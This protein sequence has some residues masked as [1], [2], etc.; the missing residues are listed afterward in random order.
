ML[1]CY[2]EIM[3]IEASKAPGFVVSQEIVLIVEEN[4]ALQT[5]I[6]YS[7]LVIYQNTLFSH[8][9]ENKE[10]FTNKNVWHKI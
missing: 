5:Y 6:P 3:T 9:K 4:P 8:R 7:V 10:L 1:R 2:T